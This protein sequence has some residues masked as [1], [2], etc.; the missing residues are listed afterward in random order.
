G[1][2]NIATGIAAAYKAFTPVIS[3]TGVQE[4]WVRERDASQDIDQITFMRPIT[5]WAYSIPDAAK[6]QE[7]VRKAFRIALTE[8]Q[9]PTHLEA[10]GEILLEHTAVEP[11][12]PSAYRNMALP[13]VSGAQLD[14]VMELLSRAER[15]VLVA[16]HGVLRENATAALLELA[17]RTGI[18]V[19]TLQYS[20]DA[21]PA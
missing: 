2:T 6:V 3:I 12:A 11:I 10:S 20:P 17:N 21:S 4:S 14:Q 7:A 9:G 13:A 15:P 8:P 5:K 1:V 19:A 18:P 16:G